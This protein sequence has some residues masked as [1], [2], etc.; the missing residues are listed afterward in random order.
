[1]NR[2]CFP[3]SG[4]FAHRPE[5]GSPQEVL[6]PPSPGRATISRWVTPNRGSRVR[7][8]GRF[9]RR[10]R[11]DT[12]PAATEKELLE[13]AVGTLAPGPPVNP[14]DRSSNMARPPGHQAAPAWSSG[15]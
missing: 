14:L 1:M 8:E 3:R 9:R 13:R 11:D 7:L 15:G 4:G 12:V 5:G 6:H 2:P 10:T